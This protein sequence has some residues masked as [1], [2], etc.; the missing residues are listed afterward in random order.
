M[1]LAK[2]INYFESVIKF[3][4]KDKKNLVK[5]LT[6]PSIE[7]INKNKI[8]LNEFER[9]EFLGDKILGLIV[10]NLIYKKLNPDT[11]NFKSINIDK[12]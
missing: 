2:N 1:I 11:R 12:V 9:L 8:I 4:F 10:A 3:N 7:K 5:S 6:H